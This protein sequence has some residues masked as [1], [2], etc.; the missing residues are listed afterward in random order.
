MVLDDILTTLAKAQFNHI[1]SIR[2]IDSIDTEKVLRDNVNKS[3]KL[4]NY[5]E[6]LF[7]SY[8]GHQPKNMIE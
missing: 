2:N 4:E 1:K 6:R 3:L 5:A 8:A 7:G